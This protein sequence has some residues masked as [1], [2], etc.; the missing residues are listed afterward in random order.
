MPSP[1]ARAVRPCRAIPGSEP[2][3]SATA[4]AIR[5]SVRSSSLPWRSS[6][7]K[8]AYARS[9]AGDPASTPRKFGSCPP[10]ASAPFSTGTEP[11]GAVRSSWI[12]NLL[13]CV[14]FMS[15]TQPVLGAGPA[16]GGPPAFTL[17]GLLTIYKSSRALRPA[18]ASAR[19]SHRYTRPGKGRLSERRRWRGRGVLKRPL[20]R[21]VRGGRRDE[22][23]AVGPARGRAVGPA[24]D[25]D[26]PARACGRAWMFCPRDAG[27]CLRHRFLFLGL[28]G[29]ADGL[30][31][32][33]PRSAFRLRFAPTSGSPAPRHRPR[34]FSGLGRRA[35]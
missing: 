9:A 29:L 20:Q 31:R 24:G 17:R 7:R 22:H 32:K 15:A 14:F 5:S 4:S 26:R 35:P 23:D 2:W 28:T 25:R 33:E 12:W 11:S 34:G 19:L 30:A 13:I 27:G 16:R 18:Q 3:W 8:R 21:R 6:E 10:V 1:A